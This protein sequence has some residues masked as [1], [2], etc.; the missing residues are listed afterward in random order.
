MANNSIPRGSNELSRSTEN[1]QQETVYAKPEYKVMEDNLKSFMLFQFDSLAD[2]MNTKLDSIGKRVC[3]IESDVSEVRKEQSALNHKQ[4]AIYEQQNIL[5]EVQESQAVQMEDLKE[6]VSYFK[7]AYNDMLEKTERMRRMTNIILHGIPENSNSLQ[8]ITGIMNILCPRNTL[9]IRDFR[10]GPIT[11]HKIRP[12]KIRL[13]SANE[14][15]AALY[16]T[17]ILKQRGDFK[18]MYVTRDLT[19]LQQFEKRQ[20][21][22]EW[23]K[24]QAEQ[25][26]RETN[27]ITPH[28]PA[29]GFSSPLPLPLPIQPV[30]THNSISF[31]QSTVNSIANPRKR[32]ADAISKA[33]TSSPQI[34]NLMRPPNFTHE[35]SPDIT[36]RPAN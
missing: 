12:V 25:Q 2:K 33:V 35:L 8:T 11:S 28:I 16:R 22:D 30:Q 15:D 1:I 34:L 13:A 36:D 21:R 20:R 3:D 18:D 10:I 32:G 9:F 26:S 7:G 19:P 4:K 23:K 14:V 5:H 6:E 27:D 29:T 24:Q 17:S 31:T